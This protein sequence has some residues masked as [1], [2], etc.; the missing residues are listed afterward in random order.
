MNLRVERQI[1]SPYST[2]G[3]LLIDGVH[4]CF[5]LEPVWVGSSDIKPRAIPEGTYNL[6]NRFSPKHNRSVPHV[7]DVSG[8]E[9]IEIHVG[10]FP[11]DTEGCLL[12]GQSKGS[13][14]DFIGGSSLAFAALWEKL[15]PVW[16]R[17]EEIDITYVNRM[18][19]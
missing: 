15:V 16:D 2:I 11:S 12:V 3:E 13:P 19:E 1:F 17:G 7:E 8:F 4:E 18:P 14:P 5:T 6:T 9:E 10:N